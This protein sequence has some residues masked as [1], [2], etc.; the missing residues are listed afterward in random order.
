MPKE[1]VQNWTGKIKRVYVCPACHSYDTIKQQD[2][3]L[4][5]SSCGYNE[6]QFGCDIIDAFEPKKSEPAKEVDE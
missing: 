3:T 2:V 6:K 1:Q 5:C 4:R